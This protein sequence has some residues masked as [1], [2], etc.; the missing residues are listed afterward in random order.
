MTAVLAPRLTVLDERVLAAV[1]AV[2]AVRARDVAALVFG[3]PHHR[4]EECGRCVVAD[5]GGGRA[6]WI[7]RLPRLFCRVCWDRLGYGST[8]TAMLIPVLVASAENTRTTR[9][10]LHGLQAV[11]MLRCGR[12]GWWRRTNNA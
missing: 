1:P 4:C 11:G 3:L 10:I 8:P 2:G 9:E 6:A 7:A 5:W 12:G